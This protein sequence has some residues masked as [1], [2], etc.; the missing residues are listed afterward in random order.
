MGDSILST[1]GSGILC[2]VTLGFVCGDKD[3]EEPTT[4]AY[5]RFREAVVGKEG[6]K[7]EPTRIQFDP[8][9]GI[10][11]K[12]ILIAPL[13]VKGPFDG[14]YLYNKLQENLIKLGKASVIT[15]PPEILAEDPSKPGNPIDWVKLAQKLGAAWL[16][17]GS[18]EGDPK[19][20]CTVSFQR[21]ETVYGDVNGSYSH[22]VTPCNEKAQ[23]AQM[24]HGARDLTDETERIIE[25]KEGGG[26][27]SATPAATP[28]PQDI[29][30]RM[31][32]R[33]IP[34]LK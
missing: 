18:I 9:A 20:T 29:M 27:G 1:I 6:E 32:T 15:V 8:K 30:R 7:E 10:S 14:V 2:G 5:G 21:F 17:S 28:S 34:S 19:T 31:L 25:G 3:S 4:K 23:E 26:S 12:R 13:M 33:D 11:Q 24:Y 16:L 22:R